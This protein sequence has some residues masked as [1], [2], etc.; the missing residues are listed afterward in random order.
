VIGGVY[1]NKDNKLSNSKLVASVVKS[2]GALQ[3]R[4]FSSRTNHRMSFEDENDS[5]DG[6]TL[7]TGD[8]KLTIVLN[9]K[10]TKI[11]I[12]ALNGKVEIHG[13]QDISIK[14][15][16]GDIVLDAGTGSIKMTAKSDIT[17][18]AT[19]GDVKLSGINA[20]M[21]AKMNAEISGN[22][23]AK[24]SAGAASVDLQVAVANLKAPL[25][26]IGP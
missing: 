15:D 23:E 5:A 7:V 25:I 1:N 21:N 4:G 10:E 14:N 18:D 8:D 13:Q 11:T 2:D 3:R 16:K 9:K 22:V 17:M 6:I 26:N 19:T 12:D 24:M 20:K